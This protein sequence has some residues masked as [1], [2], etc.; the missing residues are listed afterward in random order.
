MVLKKILTVVLIS[1]LADP[2]IGLASEKR[3]FRRPVYLSL[4]LEEIFSDTVS[5]EDH[6]L[7]QLKAASDSVFKTEF[8]AEFL[9]ILNARQKQYYQSL[10]TLQEKKD[11]IVQY[12]RAYNPNPLLPQNDRLLDHIRRSAYA[13]SNF[14]SPDPP[15][16]DDRGKYYI[17]YGKPTARYV[18]PGGIRRVA[19]FSPG[20]FEQIEDYYT[21]GTAPLQMYSVPA[22]ESWGYENVS[23]NFVVHFVW[24][25][26]SFEEIESLSEI[27]RSRRRA[28]LAWQ[29]SD[30]IKRRASVSPILAEAA[31]NIESFEVELM[32]MAY[33]GGTG[34][35]GET[36]STGTAHDKIIQ[37]LKKSDE[38]ILNFKKLAPATSYDPIHAVNKLMFSRVISQ[39]RD[40]DNRTRVSVQ[41]LAPLE[42]NLIRH[43]NEEE[44][45][46]LVLEFGGMLRN[47]VFMPL[48]TARSS[49]TIPLRSLTAVPMNYLTG[50]IQLTA[51]ARKTELTLQ[52]RDLNNN[53]LGFKK[54]VLRLRKFSQ[55][56]LEMSDIQFYLM[57]EK[58]VE[59]RL[60]PTVSINGL[61]LIPYPSIAIDRSR[62][63]YCYFEIY[64]LQS[65]GIEHSYEITYKVASDKA[66][67]TIFQKISRMFKSPKDVSISLKHAQPVDEDTARELIALDL[68][69]LSPGNYTLE[70]TVSDATRP[71]HTVSQSRML[72][73]Q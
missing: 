66:S 43:I 13:R 1:L 30:L 69:Q 68:G 35:R 62:P 55:S 18:D 5:L 39:F 52:V 19:L 38:E 67:R 63:L 22:N 36:V 64:N 54:E 53:T 34:F 33:S 45:D 21:M 71:E 11:F 15:Y 25:G 12:W 28:N 65:S 49:V 41:F 17:K 20:I 23:R 27:I 44:Q 14:P 70:I 56:K 37:R 47:H 2:L 26:Q 6:Y 73:I 40:R 58:E 60:F 42:K 31:A 24:K 57:P 29:W 9:L 32:H 50:M 51:P 72:L 59:R 48:D 7:S 61:D 4:T 8:E 10:S 16:I 46:T 3:L